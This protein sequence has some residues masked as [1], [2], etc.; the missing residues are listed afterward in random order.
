MRRARS[1]A[2]YVSGHGFGHAT[3]VAAVLDRWLALDPDLVVH[4]RTTSPAWL[5]PAVA[6]R[7]FVHQAVTD[8]GLVQSDCLSIDFAATLARLDAL[9]AEW[10]ARVAAEAAWLNEVAADL[11]LGDVPPL[12]FAAAERA[13]LPSIALANFSWDWIYAHYTDRDPRFAVHARRAADCYGKARVLLR[14]PFHAEMAAFRASVDLGIVTRRSTIAP[15]EARR[16]LGLPLERPLALVSFGGI[17][18]PGLEIERLGDMTDISFVTTDSPARLPANVLRLDPLGVD[19]TMLIVASDVVITKPGYGIVAAC[20]AH[21]V[22]LLC[23]WRE[24]FPEA[25]VLVRALEQHGTAA[26]V[27]AEDLRRAL[28]HDELQA[29]LARPVA[30]A[31][32]PADGAEQA[33]RRLDQELR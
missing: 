10:A 6:G 17:G 5:F 21:G 4:V 16:R 9:E 14:L 15:R 12:A 2:V 30:P 33:A 20:L 31:Q 25:P 29:L 22:R 7:L 19:Y 24:E 8:V 18:F 3:R 26:F 13:A 28:F 27:S 11:V 23:A 1:V 32:L